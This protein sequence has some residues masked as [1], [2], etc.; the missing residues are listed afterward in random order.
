MVAAP[1]L[2]VRTAHAQS[3]SVCYSVEPAAVAPLT[4]INASIN[5]LETP[6]TPSPVGK[7]FT[8]EIHLRNATVDNVANGVGGVEVHFNF[9]SILPYCQPTGFVDMTGQT[10]GVLVAPVLQAITAGFYKA[11]GFT[12]VTTPP[13]TDAVLYEVAAA[14]TGGAWNGAD[15]LVAKITFQIIKQPQSS[16][17]E[18]TVFL[19]LQNDF[20]DLTDSSAETVSH[21]RVQGTLTIDATPGP[22]PVQYYALTV[23][24]VGNGSVTKNPVNATYLGGTNVTLTAI[25]D[26]NWTFLS[27][28]GDLAGRQSPVNITMDGNKTVTATFVQGLPGDLN[29]DGEVSLEDL[30]VF[31]IAWR[32][33][34]GDP[35]WNPECDLAD[36]KGEISLTDFVTFAVFYGSSLQP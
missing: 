25:P 8:V 19:A 23:N 33:H 28:S 15:G 12:K 6:A 27:W 32:S 11:D 20:T 31:A 4:D 10:G 17:G 18:P 13:Y 7:N 1:A 30:N 36:P 21:D 5:G 16:S 14:T 24:V 26:V 22:Q 35:K 2:F 29:H 34:T 9:T 3:N